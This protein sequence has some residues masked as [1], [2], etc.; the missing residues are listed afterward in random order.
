MEINS[1]NKFPSVKFK[2]FGING[3]FSTLKVVIHHP[4][5]NEYLTFSVDDLYNKKLRASVDFDTVF[6][7]LNAYL[8]SKPVE[9]LEKV[10]NRYK[11]A[12]D[13]LNIFIKNNNNIDEI[14]LLPFKY[15]LETFDYEDILNY[16]KKNVYLEPVES[17]PEE[18]DESKLLNKEGTR[19]QTYTKNEY[20]ELVAFTVYI[21]TTMPIVG[22]FLALRA[23]KPSKERDLLLYNFYDIEPINSIPA[24]IKLKASVEKLLERLLQNEELTAVRIVESNASKDLLPYMLVGG[25]IT[26]KLYFYSE[27]LDTEKSNIIKKNYGYVKGKLDL[28]G[29][30]QGYRIK[31]VNSSN[32]NSSEDSEASVME[33][34]RT[35]SNIPPGMLGYYSAFL[36]ENKDKRFTSNKSK[37]VEILERFNEHINPKLVINEEEVNKLYEL[38][39]KELIN[40]LPTSI[41]LTANIFRELI[42]PRI[43]EYMK[44]I[45]PLLTAGYYFLKETGFYNIAVLL[46][47]QPV[48][49][50]IDSFVLS[51]VT[52][53]KIS[54][55]LLEKIKEY[56]PYE[57]LITGRVLNPI[58]VNIDKIVDDYSSHN[59]LSVLPNEE[60]ELLGYNSKSIKLK[61]TI[62]NELAQLYLYIIDITQQLNKEDFDNLKLVE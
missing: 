46:T 36:E 4:T 1:K 15:V 42:D 48:E 2:M 17:L 47:T 38:F 59:L 11:E 29:K 7:L 19:E 53:T 5:K 31:K 14:P 61:E 35:P 27:I 43:V 24:Y 28:Q 56:Y 25:L 10:Y 45:T 57:P 6:Y 32:T 51:S 18:F 62:K 58:V 34:F 55:D 49:V 60:L 23:F 20:L 3:E 9:Y 12:K 39:K 54:N 40:P 30:S 22:E 50:T 33:S 44:D 8:E 16:I 41:R 52:K 13:M 26:Q 37:P 21:K